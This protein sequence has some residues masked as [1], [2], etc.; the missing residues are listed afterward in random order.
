MPIGPAL[1]GAKLLIVDDDSDVREFAATA[2]RDAG[3]EIYEAKDAAAGLELLEAHPDIAL[4][5]TDYAMPLMTG[6]DLF[7]RARTIRPNLAALLVTG[8]ANLPREDQSIGA[9]RAVAQAVRPAGHAAR[10]QPMPRTQRI[11]DR[12]IRCS[13]MSP[14]WRL[15]VAWRACSSRDGPV[16]RLATV[17]ADRRRVWHIG[18]G[19]RP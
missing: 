2:L 11:A 3:Y 10:G 1:P 19:G 12:G 6:A 4:L 14:Q 16:H 7:R 13:A 15:A 9:M 8:F 17:A 5:I 18:A